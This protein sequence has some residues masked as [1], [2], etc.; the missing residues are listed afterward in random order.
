MVNVL[1]T[2]VEMYDRL[3]VGHTFDYNSPIYMLDVTYH[4]L[5]ASLGYLT[6]DYKVVN[7]IN[8]ILDNLAKTHASIYYNDGDDRYVENTTF[9][10]K[11]VLSSTKKGP[12]RDLDKRFTIMLST[13]LVKVLRENKDLFKKFYTHDK[14]DLRG[15]YSTLF[16]DVLLSHSRGLKSVEV[17]FTI[18][19]IVDFVDFELEESC[20]IE[21]WSK[22]NGNILKRVHKEIT[23]K[24]NMTFKYDKIKDKVG[25]NL[26][27]QTGRV[28]FDISVVSEME[29]PNQYF[30]EEFLM[31]RKIEYFKEKEINRKIQEI[32]K[33]NV[34]KI[35]N[36]DSYR[37][38]ERQKLQKFND[39][40]RAKVKIQDFVNWVKYN[41]LGEHGLVCLLSYK[42]HKFVT[43]NSDYKLMDID[44]GATLSTTAG[45]TYTLMQ[46]FLNEGGEYALVEASNNKEYSIS[47]SKG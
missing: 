45:E 9:L 47:Y 40:F 15:K 21:S 43:V 7:E 16:Y 30:G 18:D 25:D 19:D 5:A 10:L 13:S 42:S 32:K 1:V 37:F 41:N 22:I 36:E 11:Y 17:T 8:M 44:S 26:R 31:D 35:K 14:Y 33:F 39:D 2:I 24:T 46:D 12:S 38:S 20:N 4:D 23:E 6:L 3:D 27:K 28:R 34:M 29:E